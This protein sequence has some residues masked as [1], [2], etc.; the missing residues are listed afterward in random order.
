[1]APH[2]LHF[3]AIGIKLHGG[4]YLFSTSLD[5]MFAGLISLLGLTGSLCMLRILTLKWDK[6]RN[7]WSDQTRFAAAVTIGVVARSAFEILGVCAINFSYF[8]LE[9]VLIEDGLGMA[10]LVAIALF[11]CFVKPVGTSLLIPEQ[12]TGCV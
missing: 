10:L 8:S 2:I 12:S 7:G 11:C 6:I 5:W 9:P 4:S 1:M 3:P